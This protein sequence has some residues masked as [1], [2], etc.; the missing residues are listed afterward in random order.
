MQIATEQL[1]NH[2]KKGIHPIYFVYGDEPLQIRDNTDMLRKAAIYYGFEEREVYSADKSFDWQQLH[3]A[4]C[5]ISLFSSKKLIEIF[6]PTGKPGDKGSKALINYC[7]N[8]VEDNVLLIYTGELESSVKRSKWF[9]QLQST[10]IMVAVYPLKEQQLYNWLRQRLQQNGLQCDVEAIKF[11]AEFVEGNLLAA[12]Q[13]IIK[14]SLLYEGEMLSVNQILSAVGD[15]SRYKGFDLFDTVLKGHTSQVMA[16]LKSFESDGT[17]IVWLLFIIAKEIRMLAT[18][19]A[20][21]QQMNLSAAMNKVY[22]FAQRKALIEQVLR[23]A[24]TLDWNDYL[25]QL[26]EIDK[27]IKGISRGNP[28]TALN[29]LLLGISSHIHN[30]QN[31]Q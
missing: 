17:A 22:I 29:T 26:A 12:D 18:I 2:L 5:E 28:W 27:Q 25:L 14:L 23:Q 11:L 6:L 8:F 10:A 15:N 24:N 30:C 31:N 13:E 16:M 3:Q 20:H 1:R 21:Q 7:Q 4:A 9:K 19:N